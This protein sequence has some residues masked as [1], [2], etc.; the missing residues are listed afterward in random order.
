MTESGRV[1]G[2]WLG[3]YLRYQERTEPPLL[4]KKWCG[5]F[6]IGAALRRKCFLRWDK[7]VY[8][9]MYVILV[10]NSAARKGSAAYPIQPMLEALDL[11]IASD[12]ITPQALI[13][14]LEETGESTEGIHPEYPTKTMSNLVVFADELSVFTK[15]DAEGSFYD[16]LTDWYDCKDHWKYRTRHQ[17]F[18]KIHGVW[19]HLL[20]LTTP[21]T[22]HRI[23]PSEVIAGGLTSR[24]IFV[25]GNRKSQ[26][27]HFPRRTKQEMRMEENLIADL[28]R[29]GQ[30]K[31]EFKFTEEWA[32]R[33]AEWYEQA[34]A[35]PAFDDSRFDGYM[36]RR[37]THVLKLNMLLS[38]SESSDM[39]LT[40]HILDR[41][42]SMLEEA[43]RLMPY[44]YMSHGRMP[45]APYVEPV[46]RCLKLAGEIEYAK[47]AARFYRDL[48]PIE[49]E[50][51][52][53]A[54]ILRRHIEQ[55]RKDGKLYLRMLPQPTQEG[56]V[57]P[58]AYEPSTS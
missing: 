14:E 20:G 18:F 26:L 47:L 39:L 9:N 31:G 46:V 38:A 52:V 36:G 49:L 37:A 2:D 22:L 53:K 41:A 58:D 51:L 54:L 55:F 12:S 21:D 8:P 24:M 48:A 45:W 27:D 13:E 44:V 57:E 33:W 4:F 15:R 25:Y 17:G 5:L 32:L 7:F 40:P 19:I 16:V 34:N 23:F 30:L 11:N 28:V 50:Q 29:I 43:E 35:H 6:A 1:F 10:G 42:V 3:A 56:L